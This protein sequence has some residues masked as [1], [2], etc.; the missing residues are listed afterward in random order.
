MLTSNTECGRPGPIALVPP[1]IVDYTRLIGSGITGGAAAIR[2]SIT[3]VVEWLMGDEIIG[4]SATLKTDS[5]VWVEA[6]ITTTR[7]FNLIKFDYE[8]LSTAGSEAIMTVWVDDQPVYKIDERITDPGVN[9]ARHIP[10]GDLSP[11]EHTIGFRLDPFTNVQSVA[12][13]SKIKF[14]EVVN[15]LTRIDFNTLL[16]GTPTSN[17]DFWRIYVNGLYSPLG[18]NF[19]GKD[20]EGPKFSHPDHP[21]SSRSTVITDTLRPTHPQA[22]TF[23]IVVE[24]LTPTNFVSADV[25][26]AADRSVRMTAKDAS[27]AILGSTT[28]SSETISAF[29]FKGNVALS[30]I[31]A[32]S[33]VEFE[34][35]PDP[36]VAGV[37][38]DNL[39]FARE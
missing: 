10:V 13:I 38:I 33:T 4:V 32:I 31:G 1:P 30:G 18:V 34:A 16:D 2:T 12:R 15:T 22:G 20:D 17:P 23:N 24:F 35:V 19:R 14:G 29:P 27:G 28:S 11:G 21:D 26:S 36:A 37:A 3:G 8:F 9:R 25:L 5:P 39:T 7:T 6:P